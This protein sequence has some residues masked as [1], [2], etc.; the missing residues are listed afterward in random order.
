MTKLKLK[1]LDTEIEYE[2]NEKFLETKVLPLLEEVKKSHNLEVK[3]TLLEMLEDLEQ[4]LASLEGYSASMSRLNEE[5]DRSMKEFSE[6]SASFLEVIKKHADRQ[7]E[8]FQTTKDFQEMQMSFNLQ[9]LQL[10]HQ[11]QEENRQFTLI[12]NIMKTKH[13]TVKNS[14]NN[15]R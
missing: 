5:L 12:S 10:Q 15:I 9:Y 7:A 3:R 14:I 11:M 2:G 1:I 13:D 8:I 4:N 6:K